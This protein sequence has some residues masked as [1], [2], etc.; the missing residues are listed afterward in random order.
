MSGT[1]NGL[2][3]LTQVG[4]QSLTHDAKG[5]VTAFGTKS[6]TYSSENRLLTGPNSTTLAYDP[7]GRLYQVASPSGTRRFV[8]DGLDLIGEYDGSGNWVAN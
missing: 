6:F 2:N 5:N 8:Y 1:A 4:A 3:Q 7:L